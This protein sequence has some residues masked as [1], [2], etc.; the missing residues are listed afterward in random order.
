[1]ENKF[2]EINVTPHCQKPP[3]GLVPRSIRDRERCNEILEAI[4][5]YNHATA[6]TT[7]IPL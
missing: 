2:A 6:I 3:L 7:H 1:M 4:G 5:R